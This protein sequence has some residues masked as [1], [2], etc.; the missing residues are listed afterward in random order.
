MVTPECLREYLQRKLPQVA[1]LQVSGLYKMTEGYS[2]ETY[3]FEVSG[4]GGAFKGT[5]VLRME[6]EHGP[7]PPYDVSRQFLALSALQGST[8]PVPPVHWLEPDP[9]VLGRPFFLMD[10]VEGEV[11]LPW[12]TGRP[13]AYDDP[14]QRALMA[15][16]FVQVLAAL[17][18]QDWRG[19]GLSSLGVP[20]D[21]RDFARREL[22]RWEGV[23]RENQLL[24]QPL[25]W[26]ARRWLQGRLP[27][28]RY[29]TLVHGDFRLG[30]FIWRQGRIAAFLDWE[31]VTLGDP[32]SDLGWVCMK[33]L[34][35][36]SPLLTGLIEREEFFRRYQELTGYQVDMESVFWWQVMGYFKLGTIHVAGVRAGALGMKRDIRLAIWEFDLPL[37]LD[38]LAQLLGF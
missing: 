16:D 26:E 1:D 25:L 6:P 36:R 30:N 5:W 10:K 23:L 22:E 12:K 37:L 3:C 31:M 28:A 38:E 33:R 20:R 27:H 14:E 21:E 4:K 17:H 19:L 18:T 13:S 7:V 32:M 35:G 2:Y 29:T 9:Q 11:P 15:R 24:P 8:V 34:A